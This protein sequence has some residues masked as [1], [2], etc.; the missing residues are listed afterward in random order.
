M[1]TE[2]VSAGLITGLAAGGYAYAA[3]WPTSQ[4]FGRTVLAGTDIQEIALTFDDGPNDPYTLRLLD[5]LARYQV[6]ATFFLVG[7]FVRSRP[8][9]ARA[10][11]ED[12]HLL[13][14]HTMSHPS[15]LWERPARV[16]EE[17]ASCNAAIEDATGQSVHWFR[18]PFGARRPDVERDR[19][20]LGRERS[21]P[22]GGAGTA[23]SGTQSA[24][25]A[26]QQ[27]PSARRRSQRNRDRPLR[28][29]SGDWNAA[30]SM[31]GNPAAD[32]NC[33]RLALRCAC[34]NMTCKNMTDGTDPKE[35]LFQRWLWPSTVEQ[36]AL[37]PASI[38]VISVCHAF[39]QN[40]LLCR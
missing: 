2:L 8:Q 11:C 17:L 14:N 35:R 28:N 31:V 19:T 29:P 25:G 1:L 7:N 32:R 13:G 4:I 38:R 33:R 3:Q 34:K 12:G 20:R 5:L 36:A 39:C 21:R 15:L 10:L 30:R 24:A 27:H 40:Q 26:G 18:P 6:R 9:I 23:R 16:R 37:A 22:V